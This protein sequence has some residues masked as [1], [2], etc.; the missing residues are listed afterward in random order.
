ME[1]LAANRKR[2]AKVRTALLNSGW[3]ILTIWECALKGR[4]R[5]EFS[6]V[7]DV[8]SAWI[9]GQEIEGEVAGGQ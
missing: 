7:I 9:T 6:D 3:R 2:D 8:A 4:T 1:K 5:L